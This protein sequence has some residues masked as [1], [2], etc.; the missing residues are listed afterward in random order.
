MMN[1]HTR[2]PSIVISTTFN[3]G[4]V[5]MHAI[6]SDCIDHDATQR[7]STDCRLITKLPDPN[8]R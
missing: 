1:R 3:G 4:S 5:T 8:S 6:R 7:G 2:W